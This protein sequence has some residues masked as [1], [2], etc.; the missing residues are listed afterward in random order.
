VD[1]IFAELK[2]ITGTIAAAALF[3]TVRLNVPSSIMPPFS[4]RVPAV[5]MITLPVRVLILP[6]ETVRIL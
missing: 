2:A 4:L 1:I 5:P 6:P 3:E